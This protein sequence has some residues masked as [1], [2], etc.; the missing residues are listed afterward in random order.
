MQ[1]G[2]FNQNVK[3]V[4]L[5]NYRRAWFSLHSFHQILS[6][7]HAKVS[8]LCMFVNHASSALVILYYRIRTKVFYDVISYEG[9]GVK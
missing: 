6:S 9:P 5:S 2:C 4:H 1:D 3:E 8:F 7:P